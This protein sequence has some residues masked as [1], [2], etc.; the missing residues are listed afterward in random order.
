MAGTFKQLSVVYQKPFS[1]GGSIMR[2]GPHYC[3]RDD[4]FALPYFFILFLSRIFLFWG[5]C[6]G[7]DDTTEKRDDL[8]HSL[9]DTI[10]IKGCIPIRTFD[11]Q[12][13]TGSSR[14]GVRYKTSN[15][16]IGNSE[17]TREACQTSS[18][19]CHPLTGTHASPV[20]AI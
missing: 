11:L 5:V 10:C 7:S 14:S 15:T 4:L 19:I 18:R 20:V 3:I 17:K 9:T 12:G 1:K 16:S 13:M 2:D 8:L 6:T